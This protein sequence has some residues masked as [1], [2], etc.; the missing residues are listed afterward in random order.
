M[1][2]R[3]LRGVLAGDLD[4]IVLKAL[5]KEPQRRY[6]S[7]RELAEDIESSRVEAEPEE[8]VAENP[9]ESVR[10]VGS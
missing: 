2:P 5:R 4:N 1:D 8:K 7:V 10:K 9:P 3:R 6:G